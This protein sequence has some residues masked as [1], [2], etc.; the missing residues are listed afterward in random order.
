MDAE[1]VKVFD[2]IEENDLSID[3]FLYKQEELSN[4]GRVSN[5]QWMVVDNLNIKIY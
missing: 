5:C 2:W 4:M 1:D 3:D